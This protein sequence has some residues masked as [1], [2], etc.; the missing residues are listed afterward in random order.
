MKK[1]LALV[2]LTLMAFAIFFPILVQAESTP[3]VDQ[4]YDW[5]RLLTMPGAVAATLLIVQYFK[6]PLDSVKK[7]PTRWVVLIIA[8]GVLA[9]AKAAT[10]GGIALMDW[11]LLAI[12]TFLVA[13]SAMG[14]YELTFAK[15]APK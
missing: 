2:G 5:L 10:D 15:G 1:T 13:S 4:P 3:G 9:L 8:F 14:T 11:P 7:I 12:N 6:M